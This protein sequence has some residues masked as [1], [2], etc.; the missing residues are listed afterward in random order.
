[1][2]AYVSKAIRE[3]RPVNL[4]QVL[5]ILILYPQS[6]AAMADTPADIPAP[7]PVPFFKKKSRPRPAAR[8]R[9]PSPGQTSSSTTHL[10]SE[11]SS[12]A[13]KLPSKKTV[14]NPLVQGTKRKSA[15]EDY[16]DDDLVPLDGGVGVNWQ[17][18]G[19]AK[20]NGD[21][22][23]TG[24]LD[25][26]ADEQEEE[27]KRKRLRLVDVSSSLSPFLVF[28][29]VERLKKLTHL[30]LPSFDPGRAKRRHPG[31]RHVPWCSGLQDAH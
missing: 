30:P 12:S 16:E 26:D 23:V 28:L 15:K 7:P 24:G 25:W 18:S 1:M 22:F 29:R 10:A 3:L 17:T 21:N 11:A 31:R 8:Q 27:D 14:F 20:A 4:N 5:S 9:S 19:K 2:M 6:R 13:V